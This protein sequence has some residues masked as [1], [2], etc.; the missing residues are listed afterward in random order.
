MDAPLKNQTLVD[1]DTPAQRDACVLEIK[2]LQADTPIE[3]PRGD[4]PFVSVVIVTSDRWPFLRNLLDQL[5]KQN[6]AKYEIVVIDGSEET[7]ADIPSGVKYLRSP[8]RELGILRN[9]QILTASGE[10]LIYIDD[11]S[12]VAE[13]F[14]ERHV[15]FHLSDQGKNAAALQGHCI[16]A[17]HDER[18]NGGIRAM[19]T[20]RPQGATLSTLHATNCSFK[21]S[22]LEAIEGFN[23]TIYFGED[24]EL[25]RRLHKFGHNILNASRIVSIHRDAP[26]RGSRNHPISFEPRRFADAALIHASIHG[27][28]VGTLAI[29]KYLFPLLFPPAKNLGHLIRKTLSHYFRNLSRNRE[30]VRANHL[31]E[32]KNQL[33]E[34]PERFLQN[35][36]VSNLRNYKEAL[37]G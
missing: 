32:I 23:K 30:K 3:L 16:G 19:C 12:Y 21:R 4:K 36:R 22:H 9:L 24:D 20:Y 37:H 27:P 28:I 6:Y 17:P 33:R 18:G 11:D 25:G 10:I 7:P 5:L 14:V 35:H 29:F 31:Q 15:A 2:A 34:S 13:D 8:I 26:R 1:R